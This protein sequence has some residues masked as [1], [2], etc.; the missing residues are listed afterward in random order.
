MLRFIPTRKLI[1]GRGGYSTAWNRIRLK[2]IA[3][4]LGLRHQGVHS[5]GSTWFAEVKTLFN[6]SRL[7]TNLLHF[8]E[9]MQIVWY[10]FKNV[11]T[12]IVIG[13]FA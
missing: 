9:Y 7:A 13:N 11:L 2:Q 1:A 4:K 6:I 5:L 3:A 10:I 8:F 12:L